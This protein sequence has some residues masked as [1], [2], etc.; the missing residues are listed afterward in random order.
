MCD[1]NNLIPDT[2]EDKC[3]YLT[4]T[5]EIA[6]IAVLPETIDNKVPLPWHNNP[7]L[8]QIHQQRDMLSRTDP[9]YKKLTKKHRIMLKTLKN[10]YYAEEASA[11][12]SLAEARN[13][14]QTFRRMKQDAL[15]DVPSSGCDQNLLREH[16]KKHFTCD[17]SKKTPDSL[18]DNPPEFM[19]SLLAISANCNI[20]ISPPDS[21]EIESVLSKFKNGKA[22]T[23][24]H[25]NSSNTH[26]L[27]L[28]S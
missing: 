5:L 16:F 7:E 6:A 24:S 12:N 27:R 23:T 4:K 11:I 22:A 10:Q 19:E 8:Q 17:T 1:P 15:A 13:I 28:N 21:A 20:K 9:V 18:I 3:D 25:Q 26:D 2:L 14:E